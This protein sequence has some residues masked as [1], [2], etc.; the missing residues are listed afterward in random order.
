MKRPLN[1]GIC[2]RCILRWKFITS[3]HP[4]MSAIDFAKNVKNGIVR[5]LGALSF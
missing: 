5:K 3:M 2:V 1:V 4:A